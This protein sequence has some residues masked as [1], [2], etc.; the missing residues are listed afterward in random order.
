MG[1]FSSRRRCRGRHPDAAG[2]S[3][4]RRQSQIDARAGRDNPGRRRFS[5]HL[6]CADQPRAHLCA[7]VRF[8]PG[9]RHR[10]DRGIGVR[11]RRSGW[12]GLEQTMGLEQPELESGV[13]SAA[14]PRLASPGPAHQAASRRMASGWTGSPTR[15]SARSAWL[16]SR[17]SRRTSRPSGYA[18]RPSRR[19]A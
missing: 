3:G 15:R 11:H 17:S 13:D 10:R 8:F 19:S 12:L 14:R 2:E 9:V 7:G 1:I 5:R 6:H 4:E 16:T 18:T